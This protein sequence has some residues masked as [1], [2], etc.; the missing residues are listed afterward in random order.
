MKKYSILLVIFGSVLWGTDSLFR[1]PLSQT[2]SP[3]TIVFLEHFILVLVMM[4]VLVRSRLVLEQL[5]TKDW[6]SLFFIAIGGS[7]AATSLFTYSIK[8]GNPS[9]TVLLQK[10]QP[11]FTL[12][13]ARWLLKEKPGRWFWIWLLPAI[14]GAYLI[15]NPDWRSGLSIDPH[16]PVSIFAALGAA[17]LWGSSTV[18]GRH[19][20]S[21]MPVPALT[22]MRFLLAL[23][24]LAGLYIWQ[25][26]S[27]RILPDS[28]AGA[29]SVFAMAL[30]PGLAALALY[31][32]GLQSTPATLASVGEMAFPV[33]AIAANRLL[34]GITI[35]WSQVAG[36]IILVASVTALSILN[37]RD[38]IAELHSASGVL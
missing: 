35:T 22:G 2:L 24:V 19:V 4:P 31:Y 36:G 13:L 28:L 27:Q 11:F 15:S 29:G 7:V 12:I 38:R 9:V 5:K 32:R 30:I 37:A 20:V 18:F 26:A 17:C 1:R 23:P 16:Q 33:T 14:T 3:I 8:F 21:R 34:L 25:P 6:I 10:T